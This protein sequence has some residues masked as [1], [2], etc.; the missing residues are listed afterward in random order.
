SSI[1]LAPDAADRRAELKAAAIRFGKPWGEPAPTGLPEAGDFWF[2]EAGDWIEDDE[3]ERLGRAW[4]APGELPRIAIAPHATLQWLRQAGIK[5]DHEVASPF[6]PATLPPLL[7]CA[8][9]LGGASQTRRR[10]KAVRS[11]FA[12][13]TA[14]PRSRPELLPKAVGAAWRRRLE[15]LAAP[16]AVRVQETSILFF[17]DLIQDLDLALPLIDEI[18]RRP[19][20]RLRIVVTDWLAE[21]SPRVSAELEHRGLAFEVAERNAVTEGAVPSLSGVG[22]VVAVVET[23]E[24]AHARAHSLFLRAKEKG[25]P[26]FSLQ[27]G[28]ENVGLNYLDGG[29]APEIVSDHLLAWFPRD[30]EPVAAPAT[31]KPRIAHVGRPALAVRENELKSILSGFDRVIAVFEN[32]HWDRYDDHFREHFLADCSE[33]AFAFPRTA[34]LI[35]PHHAGMWTVKNRSAFPQWTAN[36]IMA[37]PGESFW[38]PYTAP[39]LIAAADMVITTP[40][41]V[42]LDAVLAEKPVAVAAYGMDLPAF[43]PL[44]LLQSGEDWINF[45]EGASSVSA[46]RRRGEFLSRTLTPGRAETAAID[47]IAAVVATRAPAPFAA[48]KF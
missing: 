28:L 39:S 43:D 26:S 17:L 38:E 42:A 48:R 47:Y 3:V 31:L 14:P 22:A 8:V 29:V 9:E 1:W 4:A 21:R 7:K 13:S 30:V 25:I 41:T 44:P 18:L 6:L 35:K 11:G 27:H 36:L 16:R 40:S 46:A 23:S 19:E 2:A 12:F 33:M 5:A 34:V 10:Q 37:D 15:P 20:F 32:L 24:P 45:T